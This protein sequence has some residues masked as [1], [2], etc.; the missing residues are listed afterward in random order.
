MNNSLKQKQNE[1]LRRL[2]VQCHIEK[3]IEG[4]RL[5]CEVTVILG[6]RE[7]MCFVVE[8]K[9]DVI[10]EISVGDLAKDIEEALKTLIEV[11]NQHCEDYDDFVKTLDNYLPNGTFVNS[12]WYWLRY[13]PNKEEFNYFLQWLQWNYMTGEENV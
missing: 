2:Y 6:K 13:A 5:N 7:L 4:S 11:D 9:P 8:I 10:D 1:M 3:Y 12:G